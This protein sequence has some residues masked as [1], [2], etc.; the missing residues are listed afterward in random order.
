MFSQQTHFNALAI[1]TMADI[2]SS[3]AAPSYKVLFKKKEEEGNICT[4]HRQLPSDTNLISPAACLLAFPC[5]FF[6][7]LRGYDNMSHIVF[8]NITCFLDMACS[9]CQ[10]RTHGR[11]ISRQL[12]I[13]FSYAGFR[14]RKN[15]FLLRFNFHRVETKP[16]NVCEIVL[17]RVDTAPLNHIF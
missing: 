1:R 11:N 9:F 13:G 3:L 4:S 10:T 17:T 12:S 14:D 8:I 15:A 7:S 2:F 5:T 6:L 16:L